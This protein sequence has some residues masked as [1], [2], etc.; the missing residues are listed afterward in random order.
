MVEQACI[1]T[2][3]ELIY[4]CLKWQKKA[5]LYMRNIQTR[6]IQ[7]T[8]LLPILSGSI[9][10]K[11]VRIEYECWRDDNN[12]GQ[13]SGPQGLLSAVL[14]QYLVEHYP[15]VIQANNEGCRYYITSVT[16]DSRKSLM[17]VNTNIRYHN[18]KIPNCNFI[19]NYEM[20]YH[21]H[22]HVITFVMLA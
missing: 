6:F 15:Y 3:D 1:A 20:R 22:L 14:V 21:K 13:N 17:N 12:K 16:L 19:S 7:Y 8:R 9:D 10:I 11:E 2:R 5:Q 4:Y 18:R